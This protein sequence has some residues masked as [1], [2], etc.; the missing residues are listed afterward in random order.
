M[1]FPFEPLLVF[2]TLALG[3][4][5]GVAA[6]WLK[7]L[8]SRPLEQ[9]APAPPESKG[10]PL[11]L[12]K[13][14]RQVKKDLGPELSFG[15]CIVAIGDAGWK[16]SRLLERLSG[17]SPPTPGGDG[18][19]SRIYRS[20]EAVVVELSDGLFQNDAVIVQAALRRLAQELPRG[21]VIVSLALDY[22]ALLTG[23]VAPLVVWAQ[24]LEKRLRLFELPGRSL[25]VRVCVT[26]MDAEP[27][28][29]TLRALWLARASVDLSFSVIEEKS[30]LQQLFA[31]LGAELGAVLSSRPQLLESVVRLIQTLPDALYALRALTCPLADSLGRFT[32]PELNGVYLTDS[33]G[34]AM[35]LKPFAFQ[36]LSVLPSRARYERAVLKRHLA[37]AGLVCLAFVAAFVFAGFRV[38]AV[39]AATALYAGSAGLSPPRAAPAAV[40]P[41]GSAV[42][43]PPSV[44]WQA[45]SLVPVE[46][47][48]RGT[49]AAD[50]LAS[51]RFWPL[52]FAFAPERQRAEQTFVEATRRFYLQPALAPERSLARRVF[53]A[54]ADRATGS[55]DYGRLVI[56]HLDVVSASLGVA[57]ATL[58][59]L[60][61]VRDESE[62]SR[63]VPTLARAASSIAAWRQVVSAVAAAVEAGVFVPARLAELQGAE[64]LSELPPDAEAL[65]ALQQA[66]SL[67]AAHVDQAVPA[68]VDAAARIQSELAFLQTNLAALQTLRDWLAAAP[69]LRELREARTL[70]ELLLLT[71]VT[72][73]VAGTEE[74]SVV[75]DRPV[76]IR[77][78]AFEQA[79]ARTRA[80]VLI[81]TFIQARRKA[82]TLGWSESACGD[83]EGAA[84]SSFFPLAGKSWGQAAAAEDQRLERLDGFRVTGPT[85]HGFGPTASVPGWFTRDAF[86]GFVLPVVTSLPTL[87]DALV[88]DEDL[89]TLRLFVDEELAA[90]AQRYGAELRCYW[91]SFRFQ[92][93]SLAAAE[94]AVAELAAEGSWF[95]QFLAVVTKHAALPP[96]V[97]AASS[98][99][100]ALAGFSPVVATVARKALKDYGGILLTALPGPAGPEEP[101]DAPKAGD[102]ADAS[103]PAPRAV[104]R[105]ERLTAAMRSLVAT[106]V[107]SPAAQA[108]T[109]WLASQGLASVYQRPF[110][111]PL[112]SLRSSALF[113]IR[114]RWQKEL[115]GPCLPL[116]GR[117]PF[118]SERGAGD[119]PVSVAELEAELGPQ[120]RFWAVVAATFA[121]VLEAREGRTAAER[122]HWVMPHGLSAPRG[123]LELL[124][125][126]ERLTTALWLPSGKR[127]KLKLR[128]TPYE[129]PESQRGEPL[130]ALARLA[131]PGADVQSFNQTL[132]ARTLSVEWWSEEEASFSV[133]LL[134][135]YASEVDASPTIASK[136]GPWSFLSLLETGHV[137][138][139]VLTFYLNGEARK[140]ARVEFELHGDP[141]ALFR[142]IALAADS[143]K[144]ALR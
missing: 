1:T 53:A 59:T 140:D 9:L 96:E 68:E 69:R 131:L 74:I 23:D 94:S 100:P 56:S 89:R 22:R 139:N 90:Y 49:R 110:L 67:L 63:D 128:L 71:L 123:M 51:F 55:N 93:P 136:T 101:K 64:F 3:A 61:R 124:Q 62:V 27:G 6:T 144:E 122:T 37:V 77:R 126:V 30:R 47:S 50:G 117:Y 135:R 10:L 98:F 52:P 108:L 36:P 48:A 92:P 39:S 84:G 99:G 142:D 8:K 31:S 76:P 72:P 11:D 118:R 137:E 42:P 70:Q 114:T 21:V 5:A 105:D 97:L 111:L 40:A 46:T 85:S 87:A 12:V 116:L 34:R 54:C 45:A 33:D 35:P 24:V 19:Q 14:F 66:V 83:G 41:S 113:D 4:V 138:D 130:I 82:L 79:L 132:E 57:A 141:R 25:G 129:L 38:H 120:G 16:S 95:E 20:R 17:G 58:R 2:G 102:G 86:D 73:T 103:A 125:G 143:T 7:G 88:V 15:P 78:A 44:T 104:A 32:Q 134:D 43:S 107:A 81:S 65:R 106:G 115:V 13:P 80:S 112:E 119:A 60:V 121:P 109:A 26:G 18:A 91:A 29:E 127:R 28:Y 75:L 133:E